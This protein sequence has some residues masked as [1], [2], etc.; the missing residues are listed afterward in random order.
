MSDAYDKGMKVRR[1][2]LGD[3]HVDR[4]NKAVTD[5]DADF[6]RYITEN[7]WGAVWARDGLTLRERSMITIGLLAALG[8][9][10]EVEMHVRAARNTG[11][12]MSDITEVMLHVA[13]YAGVPAA[14]A[15]ISAA[16]KVYAETGG[17]EELP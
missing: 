14:R 11:A 1:K 5:F 16:K 15:A 7:A 12:T 3:V 10:S 17:E 6:Q 13:A 9:H 8:H 2:V 4:A